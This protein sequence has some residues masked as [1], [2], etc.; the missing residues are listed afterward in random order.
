MEHIARH[1]PHHARSSNLFDTVN[2][3]FEFAF[4]DLVD[5]LLWMEMC[6]DGRTEFEIVVG[7]RNDVRM[8]I[9]YMQAG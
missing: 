1:N 5:L 7:E 2:G 6:V 9:T 8:K 4:N 3:Q